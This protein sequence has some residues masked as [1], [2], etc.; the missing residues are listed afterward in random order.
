VVGF[1]AVWL[2]DLGRV[3]ATGFVIEE[4]KVRLKWRQRL[5]LDEFGRLG[6]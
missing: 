4:V 6:P 5:V 1:V 3:M 2:N